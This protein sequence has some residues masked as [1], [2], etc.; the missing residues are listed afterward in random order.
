M[1]ELCRY[2]N[3]PIHL[4]HPIQEGARTVWVHCNSLRPYCHQNIGG[5][6]VTYDSS[7]VVAEATPKEP[8]Q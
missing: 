6:D 1:S 3:Q 4:I 5:G 8:S 2:C 7:M